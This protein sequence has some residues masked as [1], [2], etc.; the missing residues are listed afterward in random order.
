MK[1]GQQASARCYSSANAI[2]IYGTFHNVS[3][4][5]LHRYLSEFDF[6]A[7]TGEMTDAERSAALPTAGQ[8][9][10]LMYRQPH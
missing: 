10:R 9:R 5:H 2:G 6:R 1:K 7:N 8:G 3:E 4:A